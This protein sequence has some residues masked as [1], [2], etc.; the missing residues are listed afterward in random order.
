[1][2]K[3]DKTHKRLIKTSMT[4]KTQTESLDRP[5]P[6][7]TASDTRRVRRAPIMRDG[8]K[9]VRVH[10]KAQSMQHRATSMEAT[11]GHGHATCA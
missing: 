2:E 10:A 3:R 1:M 8:S 11:H 5:Q 9:E 7:R 6:D 4:Q